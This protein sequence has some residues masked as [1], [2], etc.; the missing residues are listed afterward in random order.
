[1]INLEDALFSYNLDTSQLS[2]TERD[3]FIISSGM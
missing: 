3:Y 2:I 1:M